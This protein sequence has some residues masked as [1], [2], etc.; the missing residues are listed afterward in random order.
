MCIFLVV[1]PT[2]SKLRLPLLRFAKDKK[3]HSVLDA[4]KFLANHFKLSKLEKIQLI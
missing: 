4:E 1:Y 3:I 2:E